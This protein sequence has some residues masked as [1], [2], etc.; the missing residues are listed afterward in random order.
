[1]SLTIAAARVAAAEVPDPAPAGGPT[2]ALERPLAQV[3]SAQRDLELLLVSATMIAPVGINPFVALSAFG[4][5][6]YLELWQLP[7]TLSLLAHPA[8]WMSMLCLGLLLTFG[9]SSK[10][11]KP[12]A[13]LLGSGESLLALIAVALAVVPM[14]AGTGESA[15]PVARAGVVQGLLLVSA[16]ALTVS[17]VLVVRTSFDILIWL[18]PFP[19]VDLL[20]QIAKL[21]ITAVLVALALFAPIVALVVNLLVVIAC[22]FVLRWSLR[23]TRFGLLLVWD[24]S[25]GRLWAL[26]ALPR[27]EQPL[28]R[29]GPLKAF[30]IEGEGLATRQQVTLFFEEGLWSLCARGSADGANTRALST[31]DQC[32]LRRRL[33][34]LELIL[35]EHRLLLPPRYARFRRELEALTAGEDEAVT[36]ASEFSPAAL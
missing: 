4:L 35:P 16:A 9:R 15:A 22:L 8:A 21:A 30:V 23:A 33:L 1:L 5:A 6:T 17:V 26:S 11:T 28:P 36:A 10:I 7:P 14:F 32:A 20:F 34:G 18:S 19:V 29:I 25:L 3:A 27:V 24:L 2:A 12:L 13:E 31:Q